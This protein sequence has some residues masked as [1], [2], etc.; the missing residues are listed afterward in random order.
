MFGIQALRQKS[1]PLYQ[2]GDTIS[3]NAASFLGREFG[4]GATGTLEGYSPISVDIG[5]EAYSI[6]PMVRLLVQAW[7]TER[8]QTTGFT[9]RAYG[10][11]WCCPCLTAT[12]P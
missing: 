4:P 7:F 11:E 1:T 8:D 9:E 12:V 2:T 5:A 10:D 3:T 6:Y